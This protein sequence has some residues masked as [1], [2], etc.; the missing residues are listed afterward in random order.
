MITDKKEKM[1]YLSRYLQIKE[2]ILMLLERKKA[3]RDTIY[4]LKALNLDGM[5]HG[6]VKSD[7]SDKVARF[8]DASSDIDAEIN[9]LCNKLNR[10][11]FVISHISNYDE[12]SIIEMRYI[13]GFSYKQI[14]SITGFSLKTIQ[15][16]LSQA[17]INININ[18]S[19]FK[20]AFQPV[21]SLQNSEMY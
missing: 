8:M 15:R 2:R 21:S 13:D 1:L 12:R 6:S 19:D 4:G 11:K 17:L 16:R 9:L 3:H 18:K 7:L 20:D 10:I 5:P 14:E